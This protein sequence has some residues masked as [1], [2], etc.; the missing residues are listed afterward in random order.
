MKDR[1][2]DSVVVV[3]ATRSPKLASLQQETIALLKAGDTVRQTMLRNNIT[4][5]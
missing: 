4:N 2:F 3:P 1:D 5:S